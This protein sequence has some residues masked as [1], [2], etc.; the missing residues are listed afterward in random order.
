MIARM[1]EEN[2]TAVRQTAAAAQALESVSQTL[3]GTSRRF[4]LQ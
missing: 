2:S 1:I 3:E 4:R